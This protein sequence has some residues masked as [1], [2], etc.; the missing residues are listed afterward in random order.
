M[1]CG[2][3]TAPVGFEG[4]PTTIAFV[5]GVIAAHPLG[6]DVPAVGRIRLDEDRLPPETNEVRV[7]G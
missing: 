3:W 5:R 7:A 1:T 2:G 4:D 6:V